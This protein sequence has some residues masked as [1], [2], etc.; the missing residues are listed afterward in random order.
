M[1]WLSSKRILKTSLWRPV[2]PPKSLNKN[3][4]TV[5]SLFA[6]VGVVHLILTLFKPHK[7]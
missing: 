6:G 4:N 2:L 5:G 1:V 7:I 3:E